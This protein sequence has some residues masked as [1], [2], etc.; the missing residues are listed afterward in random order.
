MRKLLVM[1]IL[2]SLVFGLAGCTMSLDLHPEGKTSSS[3]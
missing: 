1:G 3:K 2:L